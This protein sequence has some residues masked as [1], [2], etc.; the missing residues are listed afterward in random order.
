MEPVPSGTGVFYQ[1]LPAVGADGKNI[2]KLIPV[3]MVNGQFFRHQINKPACTAQKAVTMNVPSAPVQEVKKAAVNPSATQQVVRK[4]VSFVKVVPPPE[5]LNLH[6]LIKKDPPKQQAPPQ[7]KIVKVR[8]SVPVFPKPATNL[9]RLPCQL[10][11]MSKSA[12][13]PS[14]QHLQIPPDAQVKTVP[15]SDLPLL[16]KKQ[17]PTSSARSSSGPGLSSMVY[18]PGVP[19][20]NQCATPTSHS[21]TPS[22]NLISKTSNEPPA[23]GSKPLLKLVPRVSQRP[24]SPIKWVIEEEDTPPASNL[25]PCDPSPVM[26]EI[27]Q[28]VADR[29]NT[30]KLHTIRKSFQSGQRGGQG[31]DNAVVVCNGKV[32]YEAKQSSQPFDMERTSS[33]TAATKS[34]EL[35]KTI[36]DKKQPSQQPNAAQVQQHLRII[37]PKEPDV[38]DLCDDDDDDPR[39]NSSQLAAPVKVS[40]ASQQDDDNVIFV[41]YIPPVSGA[42]STQDKRLK[43]RKVLEKETEDAGTSSSDCVTEEQRR[44]GGPGSD[45][46]DVDGSA[47]MNSHLNEGS[48]TT[49][50]QTNSTQQVETVTVDVETDSPVD[51]S[52]S[53]YSS[54][55]L[56][57][58]QDTRKMESVVD[59]VPRWTSSLAPEPCQMSDHQLRQIFGITDEVRICLQRIDEAP[60]WSVPAEPLKS[61]SMSSELCS[62]E[63]CS[64]K[65]QQTLSA[66]T[67]KCHLGH[68]PLKGASS[69][70]E[71][72]SIIGYVEPIDEDFPSTDVSSF[73]ELQLTHV[74]QHT[75]TC[76]DLNTNV[77]RMGRTRKRT[78]CPCCVPGSLEPAVKSNA[79]LEE[80]NNGAWMTEHTGKKWIRT[81]VSRKD[82][83][84]TVSF[85][86]AKS[87]VPSCK[88]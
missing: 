48:N 5:G 63:L 40:T 55:A 7:Q 44:E 86:T 67:N 25:K 30:T 69:D 39:G 85:V 72:S 45:G 28:T 49:S 43:T 32:F 41:S 75:Q 53:D 80:P 29:E 68:S 65:K 11:V 74:Q 27:L 51:P 35:I 24:D 52:T 26:S 3:R 88:I 6:T 12:A 13:L 23:K 59:P 18:V 56:L 50:Q 16:I 31:Q 78:M 2:M 57:Q 1:A 87:K 38:I 66:L 82:G 33:L 60:A 10:P 15:A 71:N 22:L 47:V 34:C 37:P 81:K 64:G 19:T 4:Q 77:T 70:A 84:T 76:V 58:E 79:K 21:T 83:K 14:G 62:Q 36:I 46:R 20:V 9:V 42:M 73:P 54:G 61:E 8:T 17:I